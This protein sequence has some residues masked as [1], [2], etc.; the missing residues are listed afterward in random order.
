MVILG[1]GTNLND[2]LANLRQALTLIKKIP[3]F[4]VLQISPVYISDALLPDNA[5]VAWNRPHLNLALRF[6][7]DRKSHR[8][9]PFRT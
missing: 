4:S 8:Q 6:L 1:L 9:F 3:H 7:I 5:P 2:R